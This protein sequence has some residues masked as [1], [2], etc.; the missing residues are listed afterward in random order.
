MINI[1]G[2]ERNEGGTM[3]P[4]CL[5]RVYWDHNSQRVD[6]GGTRRCEMTRVAL[7]VPGAKVKQG[8]LISY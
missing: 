3:V 8:D 1:L 6:S 2:L 5:A 7:C 4:Q